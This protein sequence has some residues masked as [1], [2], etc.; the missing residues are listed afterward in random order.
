[1]AETC[2]AEW[3]VGI[4]V[5]GSVYC[6]IHKAMPPLHNLESAREW[7]IRTR[8]IKAARKRAADSAAKSD[9]TL[10]KRGGEERHE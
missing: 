10:A 8:R 2:R 6:A 3:C 7:G 4:P 1:M 9:A 5:E